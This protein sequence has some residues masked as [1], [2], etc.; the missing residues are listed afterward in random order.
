MANSSSPTRCPTPA[1]Q[2]FGSMLSYDGN[3]ML[4]AV[5]SLILVVIFVLFLHVYAKWFLVQA[6]HRSGSSSV[7]LS[8]VL[9]PPRISHQYLNRYSYEITSFPSGV[10]QTTGL[11][12]SIIDLIPLFDY[13]PNG[14]EASGLECV[15]CL[16]LFQDKEVGRELPKCG[17]AFHVDCIDMWL[18]SHT[19][20]PLC[21]APVGLSQ[22]EE[23]SGTG[24]DHQ[25]GSG[26]CPEADVISSSNA[27]NDD[28]G[29]VM[30]IVIEVPVGSSPPPPPPSAVTSQAASSLGGS[31]KRM[32]SRNRSEHN[33]VHDVSNNNNPDPTVD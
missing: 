24:L 30:E 15:I 17:H 11:E 16:S 2:L 27:N 7:S 33:K 4:T 29:S 5:I 6:R 23:K 20:C 1:T 25:F 3:V 8:L 9:G 19:S 12:P 13:D 10:L 28:D 18:H 21:R 31:L 14:N 26:E 22:V 32:L